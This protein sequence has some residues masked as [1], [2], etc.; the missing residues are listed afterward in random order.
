MG[1]ADLRDFVCQSARVA[2]KTYLRGNDFKPSLCM[3]G[4]RVRK[5][6]WP[7]TNILRKV[8]RFQCYRESALSSSE[9]SGMMMTVPCISDKTSSRSGSFSKKAYNSSRGVYS[10]GGDEA[11][12]VIW[13]A[14]RV[15]RY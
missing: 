6:Y 3:C 9:N 2:T 7:Y 11:R 12:E 1:I 4:F 13:L 10:T 15:C 5:R 8:Y 14:R